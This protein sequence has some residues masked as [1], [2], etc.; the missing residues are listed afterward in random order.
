MRLVVMTGVLTLGAVPAAAQTLEVVGTWRRD[1][2]RTEPVMGDLR[3]RVPSAV[4]SAAEAEAAVAASRGAAAGAVT[5]TIALTGDQLSLA[6]SGRESV[7]ARLDG[8]Q[9]TVNG[10]RVRAWREGGVVWIEAIR[11]VTLP[12]GF[13]TE[14][15]TVERLSRAADGTLLEERTVEHKGQR[16]TWRFVYE[17]AR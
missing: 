6:E 12:G 13:V 17:A 2:A 8:V 15:R 7:T 16:R 4:V 1:P 9:R 14:M 10:A 5:L 11:A 3:M